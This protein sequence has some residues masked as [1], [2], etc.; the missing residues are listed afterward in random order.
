MELEKPFKARWA[1]LTFWK[2]F[3]FEVQNPGL[4]KARIIQARFCFRRFCGLT[5]KLVSFS[6]AWSRFLGLFPFCYQVTVETV[7]LW[8]GILEK[9]ERDAPGTSEGPLAAGAPA[10]GHRFQRGHQQWRHRRR[11]S[12]KVGKQL[13]C[14]GLGVCR[15]VLIGSVSVLDVSSL[16]SLRIYNRANLTSLSRSK[17]VK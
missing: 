16:F 9:S 3:K 10:R 4:F 6:F 5:I 14:L 11:A 8:T 13:G 7:I 12:Q 2:R 1:S 15:E 17:F